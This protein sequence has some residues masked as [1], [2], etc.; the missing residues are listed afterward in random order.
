MPGAPINLFC[1]RFAANQSEPFLCDLGA[2]HGRAADLQAAAAS[3]AGPTSRATHYETAP[4]DQ[5]AL[6]T[7]VLA[8]WLAGLKIGSS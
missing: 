2:D 4:V 1:R 5:S 6:N 7:D 8:A 3:L